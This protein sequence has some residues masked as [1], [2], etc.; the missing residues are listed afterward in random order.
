[1]KLF[2]EYLLNE[3]GLISD[4]AKDFYKDLDILF[5]DFQPRK[6][7]VRQFYAD[8]DPIV[9]PFDNTIGFGKYTLRPSSSNKKPR[10]KILPL[11]NARISVIKKAD[12]IIKRLAKF[13]SIVVKHRVIKSRDH[14]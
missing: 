11:F 3:L 1:M 8:F 10:S 9:K 13:D 7:K 5:I 2:P 12:I 4:F 14:S 6:K